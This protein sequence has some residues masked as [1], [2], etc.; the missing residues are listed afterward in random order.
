MHIVSG[1]VTTNS[2]YGYSFQDASMK[3]CDHGVYTHYS[4]HNRYEVTDRNEDRDTL[5]RNVKPTYGL[6]WIQVLK[7]N[8]GVD[9]ES[10]ETNVQAE[11]YETTGTITKIDGQQIEVTEEDV[12]DE[13]MQ[14]QDNWIVEIQV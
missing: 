9:E 14:A 1:N 5:D 8:F 2:Q 12:K 4:K 10:E 13:T 6:L 3:I 11:V 7:G